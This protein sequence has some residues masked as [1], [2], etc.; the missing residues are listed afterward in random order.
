MTINDYA[1]RL[2]YKIHPYHQD[3]II[4]ETVK[5]GSID[6]DRP[7]FI[8][9]EVRTLV[10]E[11]ID[12]AY[13]GSMPPTDADFFFRL[14]PVG[15]WQ[16]LDNAAAEVLKPYHEMVRHLFVKLTRVK[17]FIQRPGH[18]IH[19]HRDLVPGNQYEG[20]DD[21]YTQAP[22]DFNGVYAGHP[23]I[24]TAPNT[25]HADQKYLNLK[26]PL[27]SQP[28]NHGLPYLVW[29]G[30]RYFIDSRDHMYCINE[31]ELLHGVEPVEF[32]RGI[33]FFDGIMDIEAI[34]AEKIPF[35]V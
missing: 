5:L 4:E 2:P 23:L 9:H 22:G 19:P 15:E 17:V 18:I 10:P 3:A 7:Y 8:R 6:E 26:V 33:V 14:N 24:P 27:T 31:V 28:G 13:Y 29:N 30:G 11:S 1:F 20:L 32:Y 21:P 25:R 12:G 34:E 35:D 16:W